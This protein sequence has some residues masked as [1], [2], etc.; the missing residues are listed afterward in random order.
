MYRGGS[1]HPQHGSLNHAAKITEEQ[2]RAVLDLH[3]KG[4]LQ[5]KIAE[6]TGV[7]RQNVWAIVHGKSWTHLRGDLL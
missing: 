1:G 4:W 2:A 6:A 7:K 5:A 3:D